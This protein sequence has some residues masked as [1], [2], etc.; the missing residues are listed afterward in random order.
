MNVDTW[1]V[2]YM[3]HTKQWVTYDKYVGD[4]DGAYSDAQVLREY[5]VKVRVGM[6]IL[7]HSW[8]DMP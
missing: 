6:V 2:Q 5:Y 1:T 3:N 4:K 8:V 7:T